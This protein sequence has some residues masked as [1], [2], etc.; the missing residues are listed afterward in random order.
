MSTDPVAPALAAYVHLPWCVRKCP[1][2]D[3][4]SHR[5]PAHLPQSRYLDALLRDI[6]YEAA[7]VD[8]RPLDSVFFGGGTPSLFPP[9]AFERILQALRQRWILSPGAEVTLEAN[10]GTVEHA[11]FDE[12]VAAGINRLS[13]GVQSFDE[14]ALERI[15]RIHGG[16]EA[17]SAAE[18]AV[19]A[20]FA[21]V[22][23]D[24]MYGL[25]GQDE[26]GAAQDVRRAIELGPAHISYYHLTIEPNTLFAS[27]PP[28]LPDDDRC[29][30]IQEAGQALLADAGFRQYEISAY[31]RP[32][33]RC[34]HN[35]NYWR[36]GDYLGIGAGAHGKL[37]RDGQIRRTLKQRHPTAF[38]GA[39]GDPSCVIHDEPVAPAQRPFEFALNALRLRDGFAIAD[40]ERA[41][42][43]KLAPDRPPWVRALDSGLL[44]QQGGWLRASD[45]GWDFMN[46]LLAF[47]LP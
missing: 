37:T 24:L 2:C 47:F 34:R 29:W 18:R 31:A 1:Y 14:G 41:T 23:L 39:A 11:P 12:Y 7:S 25:P 9:G 28:A 44:V 40:Y 20:G 22:N 15:G 5:A 33:S 42:G 13:L 46:D 10:P 27:H 43:L 35:L 38:M 30:A 4:N 21:S 45:R 32:G 16:A 19:T 26:A 8:A 36:F 17:A 3:F 6:D